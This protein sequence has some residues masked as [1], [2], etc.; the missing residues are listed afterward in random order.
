MRIVEKVVLRES[1]RR[2]CKNARIS[3]IFG[4]LDTE[5]F[6]EGVVLSLALLL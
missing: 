6:N 5:F 1:S 2:A 4:L 3:R